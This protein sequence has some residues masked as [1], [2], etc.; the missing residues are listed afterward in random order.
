MR[1]FRI[2]DGRFPILDGSGARIAGARWNSPGRSVIYAAETFAGAM[3]EILAH[4]GLNR[5]PRNHLFIE[6]LIPDSIGV[7]STPRIDFANWDASD[8][9]VTRSFGDRWLLEMRSA[10]LVVPNVV[11]G[12]V[13]T[14]ILINPLHPDFGKIE[15]SQPRLVRWDSR[16]LLAGRTE[17]PK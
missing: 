4:G 14:N 9:S 11:T 15:S 5:L 6:I 7:E 17:N 2:A 1:A 3:L 10:I 16:L 12:G 13:E 8:Q